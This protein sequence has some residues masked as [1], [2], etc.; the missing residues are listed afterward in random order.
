[1]LLVYPEFFPTYWGMQYY[2][3]LVKQKALMPPLGLITIAAMTPGDY[4]FRLI[5]LNCEPLKD[6]DLEWAD[7][8]LFSAMLPQ[9]KTLFEAAK[10]CRAAGKP[11]IMGG[12]FPTACPDECKP[13]CDVLV[14]NEGEVTWPLFLKDLEAG[15]FE[16][17]YT[18]PEKPDVSKTPCPRFDLLN[19]SYYAI[20]PIQFSRG[21]PF[22]CEFC[23]IIVMYGRKP[24][25]KTPDQ[26]LREL[27]A[28]LATGYRGVVFIVDDN[29]IGNKKE[30]QKLIPE[31]KRWTEVHN[32]PFYFGTEASVNLAD[33]VDLMDQMAAADFMWVF[34]GIETPS[35]EGLK[36]THKFQNVTSFS[37]A[38]RVKAIQNS[39][40]LV[41]GGFIIGFDSDVED[42][43]DRQIAFITQ[44]GIPNA[45]IGPLVALPGTPLHKRIKEEGRLLEADGDEDR[46]VAS[47][48][49]NIQTKI[50]MRKLL[51]G[52]RRIIQTIYNPRAYFERALIAFGRLPRAATLRGRLKHFLWMSSVMFRGTSVRRDP[53]QSKPSLWAKLNSFRELMQQ[54]PGEYRKESKR[55]AWQILRKCPE[56]FPR[57]LGYMLM[58]YHYYRFT[59]ENMLP[60][61]DGA[62]AK[63]PTDTTQKTAA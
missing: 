33:D 45:M 34:L 9:R 13:Y 43:F 24:R 11:V 12:P 23:D 26:L 1:M 37:L 39:G 8:V 28:V 35:A 42:I 21:C 58:G 52:H 41:Y 56:H 2:L 4:E 38:D 25:T 19:M 20:I 62:L 44:A 57:A 47:G 36:E 15:H 5:D 32:H 60:E 10:R 27:D 49:T 16:S 29:F 48:Y 7:M 59:I 54:L 40:L 46:T 31:L 3:P 6:S 17:L 50:P 51:E 53:A 18:S 22:Q 61:L 30:V 55:F 14:L 63:L